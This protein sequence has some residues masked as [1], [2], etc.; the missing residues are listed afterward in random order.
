[1]GKGSFDALNRRTLRW[2]GLF[3][4]SPKEATTYLRDDNVDGYISG[5]IIPTSAVNVNKVVIYSVTYN[6]SV[7]AGNAT[8]PVVRTVYVIVVAGYINGN[9]T[10]SLEDMI[11]VLQVQTGQTPAAVFPEADVDGDGRIG[12]AEAIMILHK[13]GVS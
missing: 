10:V 11:I 2:K 4:G 3:W 12:L 6:V 9:G 7:A 8:L 13:L 1:M 5:N